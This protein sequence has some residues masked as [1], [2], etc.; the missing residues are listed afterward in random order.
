MPFGL[1]IVPGI[2]K[3]LMRILFKNLKN[4]GVV[5]TYLGEIIIPSH[6]WNDML[7]S[8]KK[9]LNTLMDAKLNLKPSKWVFC[10]NI[11][12]LPRLSDFQRNH[13]TWTKN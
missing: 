4:A 8:L 5:N 1:K 12:A 13:Q 2:F 6:D 10:S 11:I 7:T 3:T 9:V